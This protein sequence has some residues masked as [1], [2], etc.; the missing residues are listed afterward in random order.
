MSQEG[1][2]GGSLQGSDGRALWSLASVPSEGAETNL[3]V[4]VVFRQQPRPVEARHRV[5]YRSS[6]LTLVLGRFNRHAARLDNLHLLMWA[7][8]S[9]HT[10]RLL[11]AWWS[12]KRFVSTVTVRLDPGLDL[13]LR[14]ARADG[15]VVNA[16]S[17]KQRLQLTE[18]GVRLFDLIERN[19]EL[20]VPEKEFLSRL[21]RL[22]DGAVDKHLGGGRP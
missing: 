14:L 21:G 15:L 9:G 1:V 3:R 16:G 19:T 18:K 5:V 13:T 20:L 11:L 22:S 10:R 4:P 17:N 6:V 7:T 12:G 2:G 8:R